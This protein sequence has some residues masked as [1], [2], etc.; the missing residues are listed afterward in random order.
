MKRKKSVILGF[1]GAGKTHTLAL[2]LH[3]QPP[4]KRV[5]TPCFKPPV[6][7][8]G[9]RRFK[10]SP[11]SESCM[12]ISREEYSWRMMRS[13][14]DALSKIIKPVKVS[15]HERKD[16]SRN[17]LS[18]RVKGNL[19]RDSVKAKYVEPL[20]DEVVA[21]ITD[22]GGQPQFLEILPRFIN[23]LNV[24]IVVT[25]L[26]ER[27]DEC[28]TSYFYGKDGEL[29]GEG[30]PSRIT[31]EQMLRQFMQMV[32]SQC[33]GNRRIKIIIVGTHRDLEHRCNET[34][35]EKERK[36]LNM[37]K[38]FDLSDNVIYADHNGKKLIFAV[39]AK[40]PSEAD[41]EMG[42]K[43]MELVM[44]EDGAETINIPLKFHLLE[45]TLR[46]MSTT[47][48][49][50]STVNE[51]M[52]NVRKYFTNEKSLKEGLKYLEESNRIFYFSELFPDKVF[53]EPQAVLNMVTEVVK[54]HI[55]LTAGVD[56][57]RLIDGA[58]KK[59]KEQGIITEN[60]LK[61]I[62]DGYDSN[63]TPMDMLKLLN[64]LLIVFER[65]PEEFLMPCLLTS[66][67]SK[68]TFKSQ[69]ND[70]MQHI[71][72]M[73]HFP[74][75]TARIGVFCSTVCKLIS[76]KKWKHYEH[77]CVARNSFSFTRPCGLVVVCLQDSYDSF[78]QV[79]LH[80]PSDP[81]FCEELPS[82]C[83][84]VRDTIKEVINGVTKTLLYVPDAPVL[85]FECVAE[86]TT[87]FS[88]HAAKYIKGKRDYLICT[89]EPSITGKVTH[90]HRLWQGVYVC[91]CVCVWVGGWVRVWSGVC[92]VWCV[93]VEDVVRKIVVA[94]Y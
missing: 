27:L 58:W 73:L 33:S 80:F 49:I 71:P 84:A 18:R 52:Q 32:V 53:G 7:S 3:N 55:K 76:G 31:N 69:T 90:D 36:L 16:L 87:R 57:G 75:G 6:R 9:L 25:N 26:S 14:K 40:D 11:S 8:I 35:E 88:L 54:E 39:D 64:K 65:I 51:V 42:R 13:G 38:S 4:S 44:D 61:K 91:V 92:V 85:A 15:L 68:S 34:R 59:F 29:V 74:R 62:S 48:Q 17:E 89:R 19:L 86:H 78:F 1:A 60:L 50:A 24:V 46:E 77:S 43:V 66:E 70:P 72:M 45:E 63:F 81:E 79:T 5:S 41:Y 22:S 20:I 83:V 47:G 67:K 82:T 93:L 2:L 21:E 23:G 28:P 56:T 12:E 94:F 30:V 37:V 10:K